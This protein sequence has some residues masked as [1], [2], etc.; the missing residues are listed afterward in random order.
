MR[1]NNTLVAM[2]DAVW[3]GT[4][5]PAPSAGSF[6]LVDMLRDSGSKAWSWLAGGTSDLK[7]ADAIALVLRALPTLAKAQTLATSMP[8]RCSRRSRCM[9]AP[10]P[11]TRE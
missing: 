2:A 10:S 8:S 7:D 4:V 3:F 5:A 6:K 11:S 9:R 1:S